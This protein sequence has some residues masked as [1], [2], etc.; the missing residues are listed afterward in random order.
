MQTQDTL[1]VMGTGA[2]CPRIDTKK[3][4]STRYPAP[5][6]TRMGFPLNRRASRVMRIELATPMVATSR[7]G[8]GQ[9][10][11]MKAIS[12]NHRATTVFMRI[13]K[14]QSEANTRPTMPTRRQ[15]WPST[16]LGRLWPCP[17]LVVARIGGE[18][19][20]PSRRRGF[21]IVQSRGSFK[22]TTATGYWLLPL[23]SR[24]LV[25]APPRRTYVRA[26]RFLT[27]A[28]GSEVLETQ[29]GSAALSPASGCTRGIS[30]APRR[31]LLEG[32]RCRSVDDPER[33]Y[34][35]RRGAA[36]RRLPRIRGRDRGASSR[37]IPP[38]GYHSAEGG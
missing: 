9:I 18:G 31:P 28:R 1:G 12:P 3:H 16:S 36:R 6:S 30:G 5:T 7:P 24:K 13:V 2:H 4:W 20:R 14:A 15:V 34:R 17:E 10:S 11:C 25:A 29:C 38:A 33:S 19:R 23:R 8:K 27:V 21:M 32:P 35:G 37:T 22:A 26:S